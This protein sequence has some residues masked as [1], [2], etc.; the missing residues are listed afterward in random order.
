MTIHHIKLKE[1]FCDAVYFGDK[2]FVIRK[3]DRQFQK[4]DYIKFLPV[5]ESGELLFINGK[6]VPSVDHP[7]GDKEYEIT[8]VLSGWGLEQNYVAFGF[9]EV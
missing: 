1:Q 2:P 4:G 6:E 5:D 7:I 8:Y 9:K 3:N